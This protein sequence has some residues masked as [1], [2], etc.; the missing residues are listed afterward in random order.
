MH[1]KKKQEVEEPKKNG[2]RDRSFLFFFLKKK[3]SRPHD[4]YIYIYI[5]KIYF[6]MSFSVQKLYFFSLSLPCSVNVVHGNFFVAA[7]LM[8]AF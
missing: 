1:E 3:T 5:Y 8:I 6:D 7:D 4:I 2:N